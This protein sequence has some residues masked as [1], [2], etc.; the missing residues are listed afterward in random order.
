MFTSGVFTSTMERIAR[1]WAEPEPTRY[2][3]TAYPAAMED[4]AVHAELVGTG[5]CPCHVC[6]GTSTE[7]RQVTVPVSAF[8]R[9]AHTDDDFPATHFEDDARA[10]TD[11]EDL[12]LCLLATE[13]EVLGASPLDAARILFGEA[14]Q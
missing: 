14:S 7:T 11:S 2:V 1:L 6:R 3:A 5:R 13:I 12:K 4:M 10:H 8:L 9:F